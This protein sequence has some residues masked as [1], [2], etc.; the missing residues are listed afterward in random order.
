MTPSNTYVLIDYENVSPTELIWPG[1]TPIKVML[2]LGA[3]QTK[4]PIKLATAMHALGENAEYVHLQSNAANA[5]D[6]H[7]AYYIGRLSANDP[8]ASFQILSNDTGFDPL[9]QHLKIKGITVQRSLST[10]SAVIKPDD[11]SQIEIV[12]RHLTSRNGA[13]PRSKKTLMNSL[14]SLFKKERTESEISV[15]FKSLC[16][17][18]LVKLNGARVTYDLPK[19]NQEISCGEEPFQDDC[20]LMDD[21]VPF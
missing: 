3:N 7:I 19:G 9:I 14:R 12:I 20:V 18:G 8:G 11:N 1:D 5:L 10:S 6:F 17:G 13:K 4:I 15:L 2:F 16:S 21:E